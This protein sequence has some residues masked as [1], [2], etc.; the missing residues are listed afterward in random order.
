MRFPLAIPLLLGITQ[1]QQYAGTAFTNSLATVTG[2]EKAFFKISDGNGGFTTLLNYFSRATPTG[3][4]PDPLQLQR[5]VIVLTGTG[6]NAWDY[7][8][9]ARAALLQAKV[10]N[11][12]CNESTVGILAPWWANNADLPSGNGD[13]LVW[14]GVGWFRGDNN[15]FPAV[16][17]TVSTYD[18]IDQII[19]YYANPAIFPNMKQIV[20]S[21]HSRGGQM[22]IR[23]AV[24]GKN[25]A[26][27]IPVTYYVGNPSS[28]A[29]LSSTR[30]I[31]VGT[32]TIYDNWE[33]GISNYTNAYNNAF[34]QNKANVIAQYQARDI[35]YARGLDDFGKSDDDCKPNSQ[36]A[37]RGERFFNFLTAFPP[38]SGDT[39]DY[40]SGVAHDGA[41]MY[42]SEAGQYRIFLD[43]FDGAGHRHADFGT[44]QIPGDDPH[45]V[46]QGLGLEQAWREKLF[47]SGTVHLGCA[48]IS[49]I[50]PSENVFVYLYDDMFHSR[51]LELPGGPTR[52]ARV[53][54]FLNSMTASSSRHSS[55]VWGPIIRGP[56][57]R[58]CG[59]LW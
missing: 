52:I 47:R 15:I 2:G 38:D 12:A 34:M 29:W 20:V 40:V 10:K 22:A 57:M 51:H 41:K 6:R 27:P 11:P 31:A 13:A 1:A 35:A 16:Q 43:N 18:A 5:I 36:G 30:P 3:P 21:G 28:F 7:F 9:L 19:Q 45:P 32:C 23:Y 58:E 4:R 53:P 44:R 59:D 8:N 49:Y 48:P 25:L 42:A 24:T 56:R 33:G 14:N 37:N 17:K 54:Q 39:V 26:L 50:H 55:S 46:S